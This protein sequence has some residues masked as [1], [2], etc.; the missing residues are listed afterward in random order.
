[1]RGG[2]KGRLN[3]SL[4]L[5]VCLDE[6]LGATDEAIDVCE[7]A[8]QAAQVLTRRMRSPGGYRHRY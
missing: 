2:S 8:I 1:M 6:F 3:L 7:E 5:S 4:N